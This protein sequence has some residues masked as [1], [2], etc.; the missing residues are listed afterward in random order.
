MSSPDVCVLSSPPTAGL[1]QGY[2]RSCRL[3]TA[4]CRYVIC[5]RCRIGGGCRLLS[6]RIPP[7]LVYNIYTFVHHISHHTVAF[8]SIHG[9]KDK[10]RPSTEVTISSQCERP[11]ANKQFRYCKGESAYQFNAL[12]H[13]SLMKI[14]IWMMRGV[15]QFQEECTRHFHLQSPN[16]GG[17]QPHEEEKHRYDTLNWAEG[18]GPAHHFQ[19]DDHYHCDNTDKWKY[20]GPASAIFAVPVTA[21]I[22]GRN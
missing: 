21:H 5:S 11:M 10:A 16:A 20:K 12:S 2:A 6:P 3:L 13:L 9:R 14:I 1:K 15:Q 19:C 22:D 4:L 18:I 7:R 8:I 17:Y